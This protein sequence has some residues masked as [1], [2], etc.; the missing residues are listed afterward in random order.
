MIYDGLPTKKMW[1]SIATLN[2][3]MLIY[4]YIYRIIYIYIIIYI[5]KHVYITYIYMYI[6]IYIW[7]PKIS[8]AR[9]LHVCQQVVRHRF[10]QNFR[11]RPPAAGVEP[12]G[13]QRFR[14]DPGRDGR[15]TLTQ[16]HPKPGFPK[17]HT[18]WWFQPTPF[19]EMD[20]MYHTYPLKNDGVRQLGGLFPIYGK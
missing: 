20:A 9:H 1:F 12:G 5:C 8:A 4:R 3:E 15:N 18:G 14:G 17:N 11:R 7:W 16:N 2:R 6:Y 13:F 10:F 19:H